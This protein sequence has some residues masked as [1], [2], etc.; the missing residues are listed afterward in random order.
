MPEHPQGSGTATLT[1]A[2]PAQA[3]PAAAGS[4]AGAPVVSKTLD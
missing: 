3:T 2:P 4:T 1:W